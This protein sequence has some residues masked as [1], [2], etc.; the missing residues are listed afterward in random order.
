MGPILAKNLKLSILPENWQSWYIGGADSESRLRASKFRLQKSFW[1][2]FGLKS[3][4]CSFDL[5]ISTHD[6]LEELILHP[7]L[8]FQNSNL[9]ILFWANLV[10]K[11]KSCPFCLKIGTHGTL[12]ELILHPDLV[13]LNSDPK[14][15]FWANLGRK[16]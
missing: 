6:I 7:D 1:G 12:E 4:S 3:K 13:F 16:I 8:V 11:S 14:I 2:E 10:R 15:L 5:K 9:K